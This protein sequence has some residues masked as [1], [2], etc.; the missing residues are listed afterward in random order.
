MPR[1]VSAEWQFISK[2]LATGDITTAVLAGVRAE[3]FTDERYAEMWA[4]LVKYNVDY[5]T[6]ADKDAFLREYGDADSFARTKDVSY[7][8]LISE[9]TKAL[10]R[11]TLVTA[12]SKLLDAT[13]E[14]DKAIAIMSE[15]LGAVAYE[16]SALR[17]HDLISLYGE[18]MKEYREKAKRPGHLRRG[19]VPTGFAGLDLATNGLMPGQLITLTGEAKAGKTQTSLIMATAAHDFGVNVTFVSFEMSYAELSARYDGMVAECDYSDLLAGRVP[20]ETLELLDK[21]LRR[22]KN[23]H[24]FVISEDAHSASTVT[25]LKAK[26]M[27]HQP[28]IVFVDGVYMMQDENGEPP[29]TPRAITNV[30]RGLKRM[31]QQLNITVVMTTQ[32]LA[33][34]LGSKKDRKITGDAIGYSSS[35]VQDSDLV[36]GVERKQDEDNVSIIRTV[37]GRMAPANRT[38]EI[39]WDWKHSN[40]EELEGGSY[41]ER[42]LYA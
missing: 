42:D 19:A 10:Q 15:T 5:G 38:V 34:K 24:P 12:V 39:A 37:L 33:W 26:V 4:W 28:R 36:L 17:D 9:L 35:F 41:D 21:R 16:S 13:D 23:L 31:A 30:T 11:R 18:R 6:C 7:E 14:P 32:V 1:G 40:F 8:A 20:H 29:G 25:A 27:Q 3:H 2:V 22:R